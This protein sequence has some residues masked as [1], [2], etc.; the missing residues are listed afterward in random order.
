M[1]EIL[2]K[3]RRLEIKVR[4]VVNTTFAGEYQSAFK[5]QGLEFDEV[6]PY[7]YGDDVRSIDWNVTA[8][9]G[10]VFVKKYREEREQT[11]FI[12]FDVSGSEDFG[13][14]QEKKR[15]VGAEIVSLLSFSAWQ[16][17]DKIGL[18]LY[19]DQLERYF[20]PTKGRKHILQMVRALLTAQPKSRK[21]HLE[22][23]L[24]F[25]S[26]L[27]KRRS[28]LF[29]VSD[30][31]DQNYEPLLTRLRQRHDIILIRLYHPNEFF[32]FG[33]GII[34]VL[35]LE[36]GK[37]RWISAGDPA[38][39]QSMLRSFEAVDRN[40]QTFCR[41][42]DIGLIAVNTRHDYLPVLEKF[43]KQRNRQKSR[44]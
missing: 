3:V 28:I 41:R 8:K 13:P 9:T 15:L 35:D 37:P 40:L 10:Q 17:N 39:R 23:A 24:E 14:G 26:H 5:G 38:Y 30:F 16:N 21:T 27:L 11:L 4:K 36:E 7:L 33:A 29:V 20:K 6:R 18:A 42:N 12:I 19:S 25:A 1:K 34:P 31:L 43:F 2:R 32:P 44:S 22:G